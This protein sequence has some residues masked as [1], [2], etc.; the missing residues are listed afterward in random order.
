MTSNPTYIK[1][2]IFNLSPK[3]K[4]IAPTK[5]IPLNK[6]KSNFKVIIKPFSLARLKHSSQHGILMQTFSSLLHLESS[7]SDLHQLKQKLLPF[8][9][10]MNTKKQIIN[11]PTQKYEKVGNINIVGGYTIW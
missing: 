10:K 9:S 1:Y 4:I 11:I 6:P 7:L 2:E 5:S 3:I 8:S